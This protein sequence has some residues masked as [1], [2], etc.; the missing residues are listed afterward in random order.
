MPPLASMDLATHAYAAQCSCSVKFVPLDQGLLCA[1]F[2]SGTKRT[3][4][5]IVCNVRFQG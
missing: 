1:T 3:V 2:P 5:G 4:T